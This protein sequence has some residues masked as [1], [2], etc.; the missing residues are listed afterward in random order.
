MNNAWWKSALPHIARSDGG[1][2]SAT[3]RHRWWDSSSDEAQFWPEEEHV[4]RARR[5]EQLERSL[6]ALRGT[7]PRVRFTD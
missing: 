7:R 2:R 1:K 4:A 6:E 3:A 5:M